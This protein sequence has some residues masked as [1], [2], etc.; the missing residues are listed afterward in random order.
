M[1]HVAVRGAFPAAWRKTFPEVGK[2]K[3]GQA[4]DALPAIAFWID[5]GVA[6]CGLT[7]QQAEAAYGDDAAC[8]SAKFSETVKACVQPRP[9]DEFLKVVFRKSSGAIVG[10]HIFG[11][12]AS[13]MINHG[14]SFV[15]R[16][17]TVWDVLHSIP[18][19]VTYDEC[20]LRAVRKAC[21]S[22]A[23]FD[24]K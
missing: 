13:E 7:Q 6:T 3:G 8:A 5:D 22:F 16:G 15:N 14:A 23:A 9:D 21:Y 4:F 10:V 1:G 18:P 11:K 24:K 12:D 17:G 19:A 20:F 2:R